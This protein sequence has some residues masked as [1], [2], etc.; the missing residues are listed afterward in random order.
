MQD[1]ACAILKV[2]PGVSPR[3]PL[4]KGATPSRILQPHGLLLGTT[5]VKPPWLEMGHYGPL[6]HTDTSFLREEILVL[7]KQFTEI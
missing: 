4:E 3:T 5:P 7:T 1:F 2:L 6:R